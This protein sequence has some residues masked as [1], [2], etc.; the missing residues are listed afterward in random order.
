VTLDHEF[1]REL[2]AHDPAP[3]SRSRLIRDMAL[4]GL[5]AEREARERAREA[6]DYLGAVSSGA[7][8]YDFGEARRA[9]E[10]RG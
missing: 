8:D 6:T 7:V 3:T 5:H 4:R 9:Y 2:A 1:E 10:E